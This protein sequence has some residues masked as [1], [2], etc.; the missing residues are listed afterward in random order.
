MQEPPDRYQLSSDGVD[1]KAEPLQRVCSDNGH[2]LRL[3]KYHQPGND[4]VRLYT[5][6][7]LAKIVVS[8]TVC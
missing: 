1:R 8:A 3:T 7:C 2:R 4:L 6:P 5:D